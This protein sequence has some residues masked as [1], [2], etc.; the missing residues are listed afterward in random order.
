MSNTEIVQNS[1][2]QRLRAL[3]RWENEGGATAAIVPATQFEI[4]RDNK[5][6]AF[7]S[8]HTAGRNS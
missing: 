1:Y 8:P 3:S 5:H 2:K 4:P 6:R 7:A